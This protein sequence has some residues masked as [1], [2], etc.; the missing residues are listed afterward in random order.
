MDKIYYDKIIKD[1]SAKSNLHFAN[2][3]GNVST[4]HLQSSNAN[5]VFQVASQANCLEMVGSGVTPE[6]GVTIYAN[7]HTQGP[8]CAMAC[9]GAL[10]Y[11]N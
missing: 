5:C 7:D 11:R 4:M 1:K 8:A 2:I 9:P 6:H 3:I 10:I